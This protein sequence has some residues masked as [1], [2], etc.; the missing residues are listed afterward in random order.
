MFF[1]GEGKSLS[2]GSYFRAK[3]SGPE[4]IQPAQNCTHIAL[5]RQFNHRGRR[6]GEI[7]GGIAVVYRAVRICYR[8][9]D[10]HSVFRQI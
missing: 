4:K 6:H 9:T 5:L 3:K 10:L 1:F 2:H 8:F 7:I